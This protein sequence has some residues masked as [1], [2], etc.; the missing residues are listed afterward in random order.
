MLGQGSATE[1]LDEATATEL[2]TGACSALP[3]DGKRVL[4]LSRMAPAMPRS[5]CC[6]ACCTNVLGARVDRLDYLIAL[7]THPPMPEG[8]RRSAG[9]CLRRLTV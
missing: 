8:R 5:R 2:L 7:G 4:V 1:L 6:S 3:L 9:R